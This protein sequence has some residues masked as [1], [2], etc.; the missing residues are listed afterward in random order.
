[1]PHPMNQI[2]IIVLCALLAEYLL[3]SIADL[4]SLRALGAQFPKDAPE[5]VRAAWDEDK[6]KR[7]QAYARARTRFGLIP[8]AVQLAV[9]LAFW[10]GGG[11]GW[12]DAEVRSLG[13][14]PIA[15]GVLYVGSL[16]LAHSLIGLPFRWYG[17]FVI[18]ERFGFNR[19]TPATFWADY[20]K[21]L[22]LAA[23]L[24]GA[25]LAA[26]LWFLQTLGPNAWLWCWGFTAAFVLI[27]QWVAPTWIMPL[28]LKFDRLPDGELRD[29]I[30]AYAERVKFPLRDLYLVDGSRRSS[31]S[32]AFFTGIGSNKRVALFDTLVE[33]HAPDEIVAI[34]AHEIGHQKKGHVT[35]SLV[36]G[37]LQAGVFF[38]VLGQVLES[39][40]LF[41]A[42][43]VQEPSVGVGI[44]LFSL[45]WSPVDLVLSA[46]ML[47]RS[48]RNEYEADAFAR[49]T[50][51]DG[52][53]LARA[54]ARLGAENLSN[55]TP[56]PLQVF[57]Q[58]THPPLTARIQALRAESGGSKVGGASPG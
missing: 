23:V 42:F 58:Y 47:G 10:F 33:Q 5:E 57:L 3:H 50:T 48:R 24:G 56:H 20:A 29:S 35:V 28:F 45:L 49:E 2:A 53:A 13:W 26:V 14:G 11:F 52:A 6:Y 38:F 30:R 15:S 16:A 32:N 40:A 17:T 39:R 34:V 7:S 22:L 4:L 18:E 36:I 37:I 21:G 41:E 12:L 54:L 1:M 31:K 8:A 43:G 46:L 25:L 55:L 19:T 51:G 27:G 44:V 9:L